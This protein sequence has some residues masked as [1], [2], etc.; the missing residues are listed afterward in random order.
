MRRFGSTLIAEILSALFVAAVVTM[1]L[2]VIGA[3]I[4]RAMGVV[5][6]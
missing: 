5:R 4:L 3:S 1:A 6:W 2:V